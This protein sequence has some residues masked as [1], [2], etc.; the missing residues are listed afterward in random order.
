[1]RGPFLLFSR[2]QGDLLHSVLTGRH[3]RPDSCYFFLLCSADGAARP[4]P[5]GP[6]FPRPWE[7]FDTHSSRSLGAFIYCYEMR[8]QLFCAAMLRFARDATSRP[9]FRFFRIPLSRCPYVRP[10]LPP[11]AVAKRVEMPFRRAELLAASA[12]STAVAAGADLC[13]LDLRRAGVPLLLSRHGL[14]KMGTGLSRP[15]RR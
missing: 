7:E 5:P 15:G 4:R 8:Y 13:S 14:Q 9:G 1:M 3:C 10:S 2:L 12:A 11:L 6:I